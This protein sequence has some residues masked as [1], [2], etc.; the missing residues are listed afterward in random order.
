VIEVGAD[1]ST[2]DDSKKS[3]GTHA[4]T[5]P[6]DEEVKKFK[7]RR[8]AVAFFVG[9][10][11][12]KE[13]YYGFGP[14]NNVNYARLPF[15][16]SVK[17]ADYAP[18]VK[19]HHLGYNEV[20]GEQNIQANVL[21]ELCKNDAVY[22]VGHSLGGWN[23]AHLSAILSDLGYTVKMLVTLDP[24]GKGAL[25]GSISNI[26]PD[27]PRPKAGLWINILAKSSESNVSDWVA[28]VGEQWVLESGPN[29]N[30]I[31]D[32]NHDKAVVM[33]TTVLADGKSALHY[34]INSLN[35][36]YRGEM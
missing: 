22:I 7:Y 27:T 35:K 1:N 6:T 10:A 13:S 4:L 21:G 2:S 5:C 33:F 17:K 9:G 29:V 32:V 36:Y 18:G 31:M 25:V 26:Y 11:G 19:S 12:D 24:V 16:E 14:E 20:I 30:S 15:D 23:G 28:G 3:L 34:M 8:R